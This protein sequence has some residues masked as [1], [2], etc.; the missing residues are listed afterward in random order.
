M[1]SSKKNTELAAAAPAAL[2]E[3]N[4][5]DPQTLLATAAQ[6][7][8]FVKD[9]N[10]ASTIQGRAYVQAEGWQFLFA[11]A[12]LDVICAKPAR[13]ERATEVCYEAE[14]RLFDSAG[15]EV[16]YG[17]AIC[18]DS[19]RTKRGWAEYAI[20]SMAQTRAIGKAGRNRFAFVM[21]AAGFEPTPAEEMS[22]VGTS[23]SVAHET[24]AK[25]A[26]GNVPAATAS[27]SPAPSTMSV[28]SD[29]EQRSLE[30]HR[31]QLAN[32]RSTKELEELW[33]KKIP[34]KLASFLVPEKE[35]AK[36]RIKKG[37]TTDATTPVR[38]RGSSTALIV[39]MLPADDAPAPVQYATASQ[40][41]EIIRIINH[42]L[43]TRQ[44]KTKMLLNINRLDEERAIACIEKLRKA[45]GTRE[46]IDWHAEARTALHSFAS[47]NAVELGSTE[48]ERLLGLVEDANTTQKVL[49]E[50]LSEAARK[51]ADDETYGTDAELAAADDEAP[52]A[53]AA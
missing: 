48:T 28:L 37:V 4:P 1:A 18:S 27:T 24:P 35:A 7:A 11:V 19:E 8:Q 47:A 32:T 39:E 26:A 36:A 50:A 17:F 49:E 6:L 42:P 25:P 34:R 52:I 23:A 29:A 44:E 13:L 20:A 40:K 30:G 41:E 14:A 12:G 38:E 31:V 2:A 51:L 33:T 53:A 45:I 10:L 43:I 15:R 9:N 5:R 46:G 16:G 22:E 21:K 3:F